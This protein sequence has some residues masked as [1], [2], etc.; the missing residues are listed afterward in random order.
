MDYSEKKL[1]PRFYF[2]FKSITFNN[3]LEFLAWKSL[4]LSI[5]NAKNK[6]TTIYFAHAYS[7]DE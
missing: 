5:F 2:K 4:E 7:A 6:R 3:G 1:G